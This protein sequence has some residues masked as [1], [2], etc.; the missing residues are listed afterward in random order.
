MDKTLIEPKQQEIWKTVAECTDIPD[1]SN[2]HRFCA[3]SPKLEKC[4]Q[5]RKFNSRLVYVDFP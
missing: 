1:G 5:N 2:I 3:L 4:Q